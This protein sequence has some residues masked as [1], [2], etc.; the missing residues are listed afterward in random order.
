MTSRNTTNLCINAVLI[1]AVIATPSF[2][3]DSSLKGLPKTG[4]FDQISSITSPRYSMKLTDRVTFKGDR[5]RRESEDPEKFIEFDDIDDGQSFYRYVP[6]QSVALRID[7]KE[8]QTG[9]LEELK[10]QTSD[11]L[12][13]A[14][15]TGDA[16]VNGYDCTTY[17]RTLQGGAKVTMWLSKSAKFPFVLKTVYVDPNENVTRTTSIDNIKLDVPVD[18]DLFTLP[19]GTKIVQQP[20]PSSQTGGSQTQAPAPADDSQQGN[21][22]SK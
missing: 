21:S 4:E 3:A 8:K 12:D 11:M 6:S 2:A 22:A 13:G 17:S 10:S 19:K 15:K 1:G 14:D 7:V 5:Y 9:A 18:D 20:P 16:N